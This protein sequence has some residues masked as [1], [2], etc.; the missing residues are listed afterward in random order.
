MEGIPVIKHKSNPFPFPLLLC[1]ILDSVHTPLCFS[2]FPVPT[3]IFVVTSIKKTKLR[4]LL[5]YRVVPFQGSFLSLTCYPPDKCD[6][7]YYF[8]RKWLNTD[9]T[10]AHSL[11]FPE[12]QLVHANNEFSKQMSCEMIAYEW[13]V[14]NKWCCIMSL[15]T[16]IVQQEG[17]KRENILILA[18]H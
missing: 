17:K 14:L 4:S 15:S 10:I 8:L 11:E 16:L 3:A 7:D 9:C 1:G 5:I 18:L 13:R 6:F 2:L 12:P